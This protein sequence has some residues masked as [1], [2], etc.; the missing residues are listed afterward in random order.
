MAEAAITRRKV[1][2]G[3]SWAMD[4]GCSPGVLAAWTDAPRSGRGVVVLGPVDKRQGEVQ[5]HGGWQTRHEYQGRDHIDMTV[6]EQAAGN[7]WVSG[8][9]AFVLDQLLQLAQG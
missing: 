3:T 9:P 1:A 4:M 5:W 6:F 2:G 8:S 7:G